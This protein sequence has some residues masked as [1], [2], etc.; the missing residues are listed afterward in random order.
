MAYTEG[1]QTGAAVTRRSSE[2]SPMAVLA[3]MRQD[4][5]TAGYEY[6]RGKWSEYVEARQDHLNAVLDYSFHNYWSQLDDSERK[7]KAKEARTSA[8]AQRKERIVAEGK[9]VASA[10]SNIVLM[11]LELPNG[12]A[13]K[14]STFSECAK[15]GGF[16]SKVA[17]MG[18][19][20][21]SVGKSMDEAALRKVW[22]R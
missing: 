6:L 17:K 12:K 15:A 5:P 16:F 19:P 7:T 2:V 11:N 8:D 1:L 3:R 9:E 18:K 21:A 4:D 22:L 14:D 13:L 10:V 20:N